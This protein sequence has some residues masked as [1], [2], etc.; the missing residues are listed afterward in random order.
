M[1]AEVCGC[2]DSTATTNSEVVDTT[3]G[4]SYNGGSEQRAPII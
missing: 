4:K 2:T 1:G 3:Q